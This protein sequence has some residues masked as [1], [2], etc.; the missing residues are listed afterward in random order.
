[1]IQASASAIPM[2]TSDG[3]G[4]GLNWHNLTREEC[5]RYM[6]LQM[7]PH[8]DYDHS[9]YLPDDCGEC[10]ACG[11]PMLGA[12]WCHD[13]YKEWRLLRDKLGE[14][15]GVCYPYDSEE[16]RVAWNE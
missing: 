5:S 4:M 14:T 9:G 13:C 6:Q 1:M 10:G 12:G 15:V 8:G 11:Q 3:E 16:R 7:S 2:R